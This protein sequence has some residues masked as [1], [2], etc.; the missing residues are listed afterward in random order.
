MK[1]LIHWHVFV[2]IV[3]ATSSGCAAYRALS[4]PTQKDYNVLEPGTHVDLVRS[5]LGAPLKSAR[6]NCDV[7]VFQEGSSGW[8][9]LRAMGY[10]ILDIGT[11]G[12]SEVVTPP[13]E[14][15]IGTG[16]IRMRV[17]YDANQNVAYVERL[18]IG[19]SPTL[20]TETYP[21]PGNGQAKPVSEDP[22]QFPKGPS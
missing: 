16:K 14:A 6:D 17:C 19:K 4:E 9:Y 7:F 15:S 5:E 21:S 2:V 18:E 1:R 8:R 10:S 11:L 20:M 13:I 12:I 3:A 22:A